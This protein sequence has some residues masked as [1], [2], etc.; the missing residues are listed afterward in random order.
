MCVRKKNTAVFDDKQANK[1][2]YRVN[3]ATYE[4]DWEGIRL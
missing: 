1:G 3:M 4:C 2:A